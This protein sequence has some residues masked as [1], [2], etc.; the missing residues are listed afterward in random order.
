MQ[1]SSNSLSPDDN[2]SS[3]PTPTLRDS[4]GRNHNYLRISVTEKC[5]LRCTYCMPDEGIELTPSENILSTTEILKIAELFVENGVDKIRLTGGEPTVRKDLVDIIEGLSKLKHHGLRTIAL[6]TNGI[7]L[8]RKLPSLYSAGLNSINISL[9][10]LIPAKY[11]LITRRSG[12]S[13]R[14]VLQSIEMSAEMGMRTKVNCVVMKKFNED[15]VGDF[16]QLTN[17]MNV[18]VRFIEWMPF[19]GNKWTNSRFVPYT[20][21]ISLINSHHLFEFNNLIRTPSLDGHNAVSKVF[22]IPGYAGTVG[23][24]SSMSDHFCGSCNR[25]RITADGHLKVCLHGLEEVNLRYILRDKILNKEEREREV[26]RVATM[27]VKSKNEKHAGTMELARKSD[28]NRPMIR[29][30]G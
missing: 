16:V 1:L 14:R 6:T 4:F 11:E 30:G 24:I 9:D 20:A 27:A 23:F 22:K 19:G 5:N 12:E 15:E 17:E 18:E 25:L 7:S 3:G 29:I 26:M 28:E 10:T 21:V 13:V 8:L 2:F